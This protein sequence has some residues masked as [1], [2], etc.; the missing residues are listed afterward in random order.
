[1]LSKRLSIAIELFLVLC[2]SITIIF[3]VLLTMGAVFGEI[4]IKNLI[5]TIPT[6]ITVFSPNIKRWV[7]KAPKVD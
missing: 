4:E 6:L 3:S 2:A 7:Y 5:F 1:M